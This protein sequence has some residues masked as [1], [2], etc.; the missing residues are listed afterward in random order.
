MNTIYDG[1][2][3]DRQDLWTHIVLLGKGE[4]YM[5]GSLQVILK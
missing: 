4:V 2:V 1:W 5:D 3:L